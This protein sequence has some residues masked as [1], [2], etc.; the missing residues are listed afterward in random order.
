MPAKVTVYVRL[1]GKYR[2]VHRV[3]FEAL[4]GAIPPQLEIDHLCFT[5]CCVN[6]DHLEAVTGR[7]NRR[8]AGA[9]RTHCLR[10]HEL[11]IDNLS[12]YWLAR[13]RRKCV[14][15]KRWHQRMWRQRE[16]TA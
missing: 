11:S 9:R 14:T 1:G 3:V 16:A 10:G 12:P 5:R 6:P 2:L 15:C 13:G 7:E 8:R 4:L